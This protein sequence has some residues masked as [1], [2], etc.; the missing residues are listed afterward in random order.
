MTT[1]LKGSSINDITSGSSNAV[2]LALEGFRINHFMYA[3]FYRQYCFS[4]KLIQM[5]EFTDR[6][7]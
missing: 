4:L 2:L 1:K 5:I 3:M 6:S 7:T